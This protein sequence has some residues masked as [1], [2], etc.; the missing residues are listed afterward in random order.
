MLL[1]GDATYDPKDYTQTGV[2]DLLPAFMFKST[3]LWTASDP[4]Y[5]SVNG[6]DGLPDLA[7]GR[8]PASNLEQGGDRSLLPERSE[9]RLPAHVYH[10]ALVTEVASD[11]THGW[12]MPSSPPRATTPTPASSRSSSASTTC[13]GIRQ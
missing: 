6:E 12:E 1:L 7:V 5:A 10:K 11:S 3:W 9:P 13:S 4:G 2:K 8:L